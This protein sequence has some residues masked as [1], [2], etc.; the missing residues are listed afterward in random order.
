MLAMQKISRRRIL[1]ATALLGA[2]V[3]GVVAADETAARKSAKRKIVI[4]GGHPGDPE[5]GCGGTIARFTDAGHELVLL[6]LNRGDPNEMPAQTNFPRVAEAAKACE[7]LKA[8]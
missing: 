6:Y 8:R 5:Y 3:T 1:A 7:I 4:C 2:S